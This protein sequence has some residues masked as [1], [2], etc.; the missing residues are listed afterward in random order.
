M[1]VLVTGGAGRIGS[2]LA[3]ALQQEGHAVR[4]LDLQPANGDFIQGNLA[5]SIV[6]AQA[7]RDVE[8][9]YHLAWGFFLCRG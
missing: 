3:D 4:V 8:V 7:L 2:Q 6:V 5:D 1:R 9:V